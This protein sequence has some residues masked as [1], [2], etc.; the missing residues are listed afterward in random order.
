MEEMLCSKWA[1]APAAPTRIPTGPALQGQ[2]GSVY[3]VVPGHPCV[4]EWDC[5][6]TAA[7]G[8]LLQIIL[9]LTNPVLM[10]AVG[11]DQQTQ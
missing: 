7:H 4:L 10:A 11:Q 9:S 3:V 6:S 8:P 1:L 5:V 2:E